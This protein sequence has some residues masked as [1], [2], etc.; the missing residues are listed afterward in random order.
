MAN[1]RLLSSRTVCVMSTLTAIAGC[2]VVQP[3]ADDPADPPDAPVAMCDPLGAFDAP[4]PLLMT[5]A[6]GSSADAALSADEL[7]LYLTRLSAAGDHD[8]FV[9]TRGSVNDPFGAPVP[10]TALDS[11][12][13]EAVPTLPAAGLDLVFESNRI[14]SEGI[15]LYVAQRAS[16]LAAFAGP[17]LLAGVGA[18]DPT[19]NDEEPFL[20]ADGKELWFISDRT[21]NSEI[22]RATRSGSGFGDAAPVAELGS[23]SAEQ[24]VMLS[25]DRRTVYFS[26]NRTAPG[27]KGGF[28]IFRAHRNSVSDGF[29]APAVVP[30]LNSKTDDAARWLSADSCRLYMHVQV[31]GGFNLFV[32]TRHPAM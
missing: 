7:S 18:P 25:A 29:G 12:S 14:A 30:E 11:T 1:R 5:D 26:S 28:D 22:F 16:L 3:P 19:D 23:S 4:Q 32:A 8:L 31:T 6:P 27:A 15:H 9:A 2:G 13:D 10:L 17:A 20:T 21:G 24:H